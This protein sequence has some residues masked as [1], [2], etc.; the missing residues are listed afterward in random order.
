VRAAAI[1]FITLAFAFSASAASTNLIQNGN[2]E[3]NG[4]PNSNALTGWTPVNEEGGNG[5]WLAQSGTTTPVDPSFGNSL[6]FA[7][8]MPPPPEGSF[9]AMVS[10]GSQGSHI[11][12][13]EVTIPP[14]ASPVLSFKFYVRS[15]AP[16]AS[17][18]TLSFKGDTNQQFRV[19]IIDR[20]ADIFTLDVLQNILAIGTGN[21]LRIGYD[22]QTATLSGLGG[23]TVRLRFIEVDNAYCLNVGID[24]VRLETEA[25]N[26]A[27]AITR[28][29]SNPGRV[30]F[31]GS[32]T[33]TWSTQH[34]T[35]VSIDGIG[36]VPLSGTRSVSMQK[37]TEF[38]MT[39]TGA[40]GT[41]TRSVFEAVDEPGPSIR[42]GA[43]PSF[44]QKGQS[45]TLTWTTTGATDVSLDNNIGAVG[46]SGSLIVT[47]TATTE[48][49]LSATAAGI[50]STSRATVFVDPGDVPIITVSSYPGGIV[51]FE[52][53]AGAVDHYTLTN[54]GRV[55]TT[56]TLTQ[57]G[58]F[59]T[60]SPTSFSLP[61]NASQVVTITST[62]G[63]GGKYD[64]VSLIAG[65][66]VPSGFSVPVRMFLAVAPT[67]TVVPTTAVART[68]VAAPAGE[69]PSGSVTFTNSGTGTL[70]G[71]ASSDVAWLIPESGLIVIGPG[72]TR[73]V[74]FT[75]NRALRPDASSL[76]GAA[77]AILTL[78]YVETTGSASSHRLTSQGSGTTSSIS[79]SIVDIVKPGAIPGAPPPLAPGEVA[80]FVPGLFQ[81]L[82]STG[83]LFV[84]VLG[85]SISDLKLYLAAPGKAPLFGS[86]DQLAPN[87]SVVLPSILSS[88]FAT[89]SPTGTIQAR[90]ASL[91]RVLLSGVQA[92]TID[93]SVGSFITALPMFRS[94]RSAAP[95]EI[96]YLTGVEKSQTR[97]TNMFVQEVAG[98]AV[99]VRIEFLDAAGSV[100]ST[101]DSEKVDAFS[102]LSL[103]DAIPESAISARLTNAA[104][105]AG[106]IVAYAQ[107]VDTS[108]KDAWIVNGQLLTAASNDQIIAV[109]PPPANVSTTTNTMYL[110]NPG[111]QPLKITLDSRFSAA[112]RRAARPSGGTAFL[113]SVTIESGRTVS[114][115]I[116]FTDGY[117]KLS[118][119]SPFVVAARST[120]TMRGREGSF[121]SALPAYPTS[122]ALTTGES[123]RFGGVDDAS[124]ATVLA[125]AP[126]TYRSNVGLIE[127]A[128]QPSVVR[129]TLRFSFS[130]GSKTTALGVSSLNLSVPANRL[131]MVSDLARTIIGS[132]RDGFGDLRN[133]Q[134]DVDVIGGDGR[135]SP[136]L[137]TIDNGSAD[138]ALRSP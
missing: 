129:L 134:L 110:L 103:N 136:F 133:M 39:A 94:D 121:G 47:P 11:L 81:S 112:R 101:R 61:A 75:T 23:R 12:Y 105:S 10:Q 33:L 27:P 1:A 108:S 57:Q 36:S 138:S 77:V 4:G 128:G 50:T 19:D 35:A 52:G 63:V 54:L 96:V 84:S 6:C 88:V 89:T 97:L 64:G 20:D 26:P 90:S 43:E 32:T 9:A 120:N 91:S 34:A 59:F 73:A 117:L 114:L 95:G 68:E 28:F 62:T 135:I 44:I 107:V 51:A 69:N 100:V 66:G 17:P 80:F 119:D 5:A 76:G 40:G 2:F 83:D 15:G 99:T 122:A 102:L 8:D 60:Q 65:N 124:R 67:G 3:S 18:D 42:F 24:D 118:A 98:Q 55:P 41:A 104:S 116:G 13:Q 79:V 130:A 16:L 22:L 72:Q 92:S 123:R 87:A 21:A 37:N 74:T 7:S 58:D 49:T 70:Q 93:S 131:V 132:A 126:V 14:G 29:T 113:S 25:V 46:A 106:R 127:S 45:A 38:A 85:N 71:I 86:L 30:P 31:A 137:Q 109:A 111:A 53:L 48:Y 56:I 115:P 78:T 82:G 125:A